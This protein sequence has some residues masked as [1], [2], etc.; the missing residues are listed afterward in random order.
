ML[1][2]Q[3]LRS[4]WLILSLVGCLTGFST[5]CGHP[6]ERVAADHE[7]SAHSSLTGPLGGKLKEILEHK[8]ASECEDKQRSIRTQIVDALDERYAEIQAFT[9]ATPSASKFFRRVPL[10]PTFVRELANPPNPKP[11]WADDKSNWEFLFEDYSKIKN[12]PVN[13]RWAY[14]DSDVRF[15]MS[16]D[17]DRVLYGANMY[18]NKDSGPSLKSLLAEVLRCDHEPTCL[19]PVLDPPLTRFVLENPYYSSLWFKLQ[20]ASSSDQKRKAIARLL[21]EVQGDVPRYSFRHNSAVTRPNQHELK[22][23]LVAGPFAGAETAFAKY[24]ESLWRSSELSLKID[25]VQATDVPEAFQVLLGEVVGSRS[26]V[27][28][29]KH[30]V[31]LYPDV[32]TQSIAHEIGHVLGFKDRYFTTWKPASCEYVVQTNAEDL[33]SDPQEG[34]VMPDEWAE[35]E[36]EYPLPITII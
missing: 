36:R 33:M 30:I 10:G 6:V 7:R 35:L 17:I 22:L 19:T 21:S 28:F 8:Y 23:P 29:K 31:Q 18:L 32:R 20:N 9:K 26:F 2:T 13:A 1:T 4:Q 11:G 14:L 12:Q 24:V 27:N 34:S 15:M 16:D 25:W 3:T 5:A